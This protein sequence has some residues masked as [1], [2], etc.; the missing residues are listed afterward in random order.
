ADAIAMA[1]ALQ[2]DPYLPRKAVL[3]RDEEITPCIRC[4]TCFAERFSNKLR[5]CAV[6]PV[7]GSETEFGNICP[8]LI[9]KRVLVAGGG[10]GGMQAAITAA[11]RGHKV[12]LC[13][14]SGELGGAL[15]YEKNIPFKADVY[16]LIRSKELELRRAGVEVR[17]NTPVTKDYAEKESPDALVVAIG[18]VPVRPAFEES[19]GPVVMMAEEGADRLDSIGSEVVIL[20]GG[21]VG[22]E[23]AIF[24]ADNGRAVTIAEMTD[25]LASNSNANQQRTVLKKL[26]EY[27]NITVK[28]GYTGVRVDGKGLVCVDKTGKEVLIEAD[29]IIYALGQRSLYKE[30]EQLLDTAPEVILVGDCVRP[31][32]VKEAIS[33]GFHAA[34]D[35]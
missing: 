4:L 9:S 10:P 19:S 31:G 22:C 29:T 3:G 1:R 21:L 23:L 6:N 25:T 20:G 12:V 26:N 13:E 24:L 28:T 7:I 15:K 33:R 34:M 8:A 35:I 16:D 14:K 32:T 30:A 5:I 18:A 17:L 27:D 11:R 2:A